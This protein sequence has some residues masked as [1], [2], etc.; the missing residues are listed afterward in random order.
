MTLASGPRPQDQWRP[1]I[2]LPRTPDE[3]ET[4]GR[5]TAL[6]MDEVAMPDRRRSPGRRAQSSR[7]HD[8]AGHELI[9]LL[10]AKLCQRLAIDE[11]RRR[12]SQ[13]YRLN[14]LGV[15]RQQ[16]SDFG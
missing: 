13:I 4:F 15:L 1:T 11:E 8:L 2:P 14:V 3:V 16:G 10:G 9:E 12:A 5:R 6:V 7:G